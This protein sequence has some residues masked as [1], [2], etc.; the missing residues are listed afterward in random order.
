MMV[1]T[2]AGLAD[3]WK[4]DDGQTQDVPGGFLWDLADEGS[5]Y[6]LTKI[7]WLTAWKLRRLT[8]L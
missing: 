5:W 4:M 1:G 8:E 2:V 3:Y 7:I 6:V